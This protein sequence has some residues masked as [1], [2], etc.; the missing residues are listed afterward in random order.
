VEG[1]GWKKRRRVVCE[2]AGLHRSQDS[3]QGLRVLGCPLELCLFVEVVGER[4][5]VMFEDGVM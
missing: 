4:K 1:R 3:R 2:A 5:C